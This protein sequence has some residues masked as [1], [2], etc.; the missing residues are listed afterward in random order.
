VPPSRRHVTRRPRP[1]YLP[2]TTCTPLPAPRSALLALRRCPT[3]ATPP[4]VVRKHTTGV[5]AH[6]TPP[7]HFVGRPSQSHGPSTDPSLVLGATRVLFLRSTQYPPAKRLKKKKNPVAPQ[8][9]HDPLRRLQHPHL[10][11]ALV[12]PTQGLSLY[13]SFPPLLSK[14][15]PLTF[16]P[17]K[18]RETPYLP[19]GPQAPRDNGVVSHAYEGCRTYKTKPRGFLPGTYVNPHTFHLPIPPSPFPV[20]FA[21]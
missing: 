8:T 13:P 11:Y 9:A 4:P 16:V 1:S 10:W 5:L 2:T 7:R 18:I 21:F 15:S 19:F 3:Y 14:I 17:K 6:T 12:S 20:Y